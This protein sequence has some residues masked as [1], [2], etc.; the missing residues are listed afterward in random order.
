MACHDRFIVQIELVP[1]NLRR[2]GDVAL[3]RA[4]NRD[5]TRQDRRMQLQIDDV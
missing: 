1:L 4:G 2:I 5:L 3:T